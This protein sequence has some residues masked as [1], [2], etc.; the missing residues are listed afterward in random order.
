GEVR[1]KLYPKAQSIEWS[2]PGVGLILNQSF[3]DSYLL[4]AGVTYFFNEHEGLGIEWAHA[5]NQDK[6]ERKCLENFYNDPADL[7]S[8]VCP[9]SDNNKGAPLYDSKGSPVRGANF[10]PAYMPIRELNN[11]FLVN[12]VYSPIY[13]KQIAF[14]ST[15]SHFDLFL[16]TGLGIGLSTF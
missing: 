1:N 9:T 12:Y 5:V 4:H 16:V 15:T 7:I 13:G 10:G 11:L 8:A 14:L 3:L 6:D 2:G